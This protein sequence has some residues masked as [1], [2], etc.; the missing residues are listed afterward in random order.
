VE[1]IANGLKISAVSE[2]DRY[3]PE[4]MVEFLNLYRLVIETI[5]A[6]PDA[7]LSDL[8]RLCLKSQQSMLDRVSTGS[9]SDL[10]CD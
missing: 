1:E 6:D 7:R 4:T 8:V 2:V 10:V 3:K 9:G 5:V